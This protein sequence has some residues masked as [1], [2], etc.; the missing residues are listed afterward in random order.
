MRHVKWILPAAVLLGLQIWLF[1]TPWGPVS[2]TSRPIIFLSFLILFGLPGLGACWMLYMVI[3]YEKRALPLALVAL[4]PYAFLW[5]RFERAQAHKTRQP[6][7]TES[8]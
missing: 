7:P 2:L 8:R 6:T 3:R 4:F 5:Y 1:V